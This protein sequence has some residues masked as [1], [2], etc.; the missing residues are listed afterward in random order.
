M[1]VIS[2]PAAWPRPAE[3]RL[4][5]E[6]AHARAVWRVRPDGV[7]AHDPRHPLAADTAARGTPPRLPAQLHKGK[8]ARAVERGSSGPVRWPATESRALPPVAPGQNP[9]ALATMLYRATNRLCR[10]GAPLEN[11]AHSASF[12]PPDNNAPTNPATKH[13]K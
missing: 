5:V 8:I 12:H 10:A 11:L 3:R 13:L 7:P 4:A 6:Q 9:Q 2:A 1:R